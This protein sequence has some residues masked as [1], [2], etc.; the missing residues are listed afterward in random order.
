[1]AVTKAHNKKSISAMQK[2]V[3]RL[4]RR[5]RG[6]RKRQRLREVIGL[7]TLKLGLRD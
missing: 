1:V 5:G 6:I 3:I 7:N 2:A 4:L